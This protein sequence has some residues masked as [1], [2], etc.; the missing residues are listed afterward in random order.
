LSGKA[1]PVDPARAASHSGRVFAIALALAAN[2]LAAWF[3]LRG[4]WTV[5]SLM[6]LFWFENGLVGLA[7]GARLLALPGPPVLHGMKFVL[8][9]FFALH[10]GLFFVLHGLLVNAVFVGQWEAPTAAPGFLVA[11]VAALVAIAWQAGSAHVAYVAPDHSRDE[12]AASHQDPAT[13]RRLVL[14]LVK[15]GVAPY[16]RVVVLHLVLVLGGIASL[17]LDSPW[18]AIALLLVLKAAIEVAQAAG[19]GAKL[20]ASMR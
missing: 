3:A 4:G 19:V 6:T 10:F 8:V 13:A 7:T 18:I 15:V 16:P 12:V 5:G 2:A 11:L 1:P 9:P 17:A 14:P 20:L